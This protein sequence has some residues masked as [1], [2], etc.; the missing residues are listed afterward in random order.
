MS[1]SAIPDAL[2][3]AVFN[4]DQGRCGYCRLAQF[5]QGAIF[6]INHVLPRSKGGKTTI[7]NLV[8]QCPHC[9][10]HKSN[11]IEGVDPET[12]DRHPLFN[13]LH[14]SWSVH[15][16][17]HIDATLS[18]RTPSGRV[19][20]IELKMNDRLPRI[21]RRMQLILSLLVADPISR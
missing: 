10:L 18:G 2:R 17:L 5:G 4:R 11:K 20:V 21:A 16:E 15:F 8:L 13:P 3:L 1:R 7:E 14:A 6:H 12:Q 19:T 9:S